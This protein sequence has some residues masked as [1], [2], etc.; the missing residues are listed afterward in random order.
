MAPKGGLDRCN[1]PQR[2]LF[3]G[4]AQ[5]IAAGLGLASI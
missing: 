5:Q 3:E 4:G 1:N 2:H